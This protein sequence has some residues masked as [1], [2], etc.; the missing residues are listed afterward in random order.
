MNKAN[1]PPPS[2]HYDLAVIGAGPAGMMAALRASECGASVIL[3]EKNHKP[4]IKLLMTGKERC[5]ITNADTDVQRFASSFGKKGKFLLSALYRFGVRETIDFF[6]GNNLKTVVER[7]G[8]IFPESGRA[9]DVHA[10]LL[11]LIKKNS[12]KLL[13]DCS[14]KKIVHKQHGIERIILDKNEITAKNY[15]ISTGGLSYPGTGSTGDGYRW[16][17][18]MGHRIVKPEPSLTPIIVKES[19]I[20]ELE[21]LSLKNVRISV[22][23]ENKKMDERFG[24]ALFTDRGMSGPVILDMSKTIGGLLA[25]GQTDLFIDF[26]PALD[27]AILDKRILREL[28]RHKNRAIKNMLP[29][30]LPRK[31]IPVILGRAG[32]NADTKNNSITKEERKK[33]R[34]LLKQFPLTIRKLVGFNKA[35]ITT[36]GVDLKEVDPKT[37]RSRIIQN[38][39][40]AGEVL[41]LD[42]P[43]GGYNLQVCWSTGHLAGES[44]AGN[45]YSEAE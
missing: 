13:T 23:I 2:Q 31:L 8:R 7:G 32:I 19:W 9:E 33:L 44:A 35:I 43:T 11:R 45:R 16:A 22:Y 34:L 37:M 18:Q 26:K 38:L 12:I 1:I 30:L 17:K 42:G 40:F 39:Y 25:R 21:G 14:I 15:L 20:Q 5:N 27:S 41:D 4:G 29:E 6:H 24:E 10:L 28:E 3:L 36:G